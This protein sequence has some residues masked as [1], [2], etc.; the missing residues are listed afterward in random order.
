M[1]NILKNEEENKPISI[2][3]YLFKRKQKQQEKEKKEPK[4]KENSFA[5]VW[6]ELYI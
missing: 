3:E 5:Y 6:S 2:E 1:E 4:K